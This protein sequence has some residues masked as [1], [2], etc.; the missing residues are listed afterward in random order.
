MNMKRVVKERE[1]RK[2]TWVYFINQ[3]LK[4]IY[5]FLLVFVAIIFV[6]YLCGIFL[7]SMNFIGWEFE[8]GIWIWFDGL[9][10]LI[11]LAV[12]ILIV[13][14]GLCFIVLKINKWLKSNWKKAK[15]RA[16]KELK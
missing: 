5:F 13:G 4:E 3:K 2:L 15:E 1:S 9:M 8:Q 7:K 16:E 6:P 11:F 14:V 12:V 10:F